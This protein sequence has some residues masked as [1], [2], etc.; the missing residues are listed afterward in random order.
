[1]MPKIYFLVN[2]SLKYNKWIMIGLF[3]A[4]KQLCLIYKYHLLSFSLV[5]ELKVMC[6]KVPLRF[7]ES[8]L[9][10][11]SRVEWH[12]RPTS[13]L[14]VVTQVQWVVWSGSVCKFKLINKFK[15]W[16]NSFIYLS[17]LVF[18]LSFVGRVWG[19]LEMYA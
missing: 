15:K 11:H 18:I 6:D 8:L 2:Y 16:L 9:F 14:H 12:H 7:T 5:C 13:G 1:M 19:M 4:Y 10:L 3:S 17:I